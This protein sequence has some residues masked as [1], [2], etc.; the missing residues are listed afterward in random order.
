MVAKGR[1]CYLMVRDAPGQED[2]ASL[3]WGVDFNLEEGE[4]L[5]TDHEDLSNAQYAIFQMMQ[6]LKGTF[7]DAG[8]EVIIG[9]APS[10]FAVPKNVD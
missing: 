2:E 8:A 6:I 1:V 7:E 3:E 5:P 4:E 9:E 10:G